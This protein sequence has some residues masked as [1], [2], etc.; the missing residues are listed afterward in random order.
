M[1]EMMLADA[2]AAHGFSYAALRYFNVAGADPAGRTGQSTRGA[3]HLIK[4]ACEAALGKRDG[5]TV[6]G[7]DYPTPDGTCVRDY[8][9]VSDLAA[10]HAD[11][12][13]YLRAGGD[14]L[15]ANCGYGRGFSVL[16]VID[17]VKRVSG[18]DFPVAFGERR[19]GDPSA[20][21]ASP[22]LLMA[23]A[24]LAAA[25]R[26]SRRESCAMRSPGRTRSPAATRSIEQEPEGKQATR[27]CQRP[28]HARGHVAGKRTGH[29]FANPKLL[30]RSGRRCGFLTLAKAARRQTPPDGPSTLAEG[31]DAYARHAWEDAYRALSL[32]DQATPL[33]VDDLD[34]LG[35]AAAL[36]GRGDDFLKTLERVHNLHLEAGEALR[37]AR[38]AFWLGMRLASLGEIGRATGWLARA[39]RLIEGEGRDCVEAGYLLLPVMHRHLAAGDYQA[40]CGTAAG[41]IRIG[42]RFGD[43]DL[44]AF[45]RNLQG[46]ALLRQGQIADGLALLTRPCSR[47]PRAIYRHSSLV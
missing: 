36:I 10:A 2:S 27:P 16:E 34:R 42:D 33:G 12:L 41:A 45:A 21:V 38:S 43:A 37:A 46:R 32:A 23:R 4:V 24:R 39:E 40:A 25:A 44:I 18:S 31:R 30:G 8:I 22:A 1:T 35:L 5:M 47:Q 17:T 15:V 9:H 19:P 26:R 3:T 14:S 6:F 7:T 20:I 29:F 13:R 11:A 28:S